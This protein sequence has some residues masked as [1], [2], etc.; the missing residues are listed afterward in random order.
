MPEGQAGRPM[1]L[2]ERRVRISFNPNQ[3]PHVGELKTA[4]AGFI[5]YCQ[6]LRAISRDPSRVM[7]SEDVGE[8]NRLIAL[9]QTHAED[10]AMWAVKAATIGLP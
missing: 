5:D 3:A 2:G 8:L 1:T 4:Q 10:A 9:A 7:G 6:E